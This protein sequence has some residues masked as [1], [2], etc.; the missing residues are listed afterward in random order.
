MRVKNQ[1]CNNSSD[2]SGD[3]DG[4]GHSIFGGTNE[5]MILWVTDIENIL[6]GSVDNLDRKDKYDSDEENGGFEASDLEN[7]NS[8]TNEDRDDGMDASVLLI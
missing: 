3:Q 5:D 2:D 4:T 8:Y 1:E 6:Y 7:V